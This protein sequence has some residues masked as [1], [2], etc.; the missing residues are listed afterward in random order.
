MKKYLLILIFYTSI[1][2][3]L[4][5]STIL[6]PNGMVIPSMTQANRPASPTTGQLIYQTDGTT[7][8]YIWNG[9][10]WMTVSGSGGGSGTVTNVSANAPISVTNS[11]TTPSLSISQA[12]AT[13]NGF[14]SSSD[15]TTFNNKQN[16][17]PKAD[18]F[19]NGYL[20]G[21]DWY[22]FNTKFSLP[23]FTAG[24]VFFSKNSA[25]GES[26]DHFFFNDTEKRLELKGLN[27]GTP[28][29]GTANWISGVFGG[30][31]GNKVVMGVNTGEATIGGHNYNFT[32]WTPLIINP[33]GA[34]KI[35]SLI[36]TG[37]RMVVAEADGTLSSQSMVAREVLPPL[38]NFDSVGNSYTKIIKATNST[39]GYLSS[40]D[41]SIF[42]N[43]QNALSNANTS[44]SGILTNA[45]WNIFYGKFT[46]P[47]LTSGSLLFSNGSSITENNSNLFWNNSSNRLGIKSLY[48]SSSLTVNSADNQWFAA[49]F[50]GTGTGRVVLGNIQN[51]ATIGALSNDFGS[52][53][54]LAIN[55][56]GGN[57]VIGNHTPTEKLQVI[58]NGTFSN[59]LAVGSNVF[60][61]PST[62][63]EINST[64]GTLLLPRLISSTISGIASPLNGMMA[65]NSEKHEIAFY[66]NNLWTDLLFNDQRL[67]ASTNITQTFSYTGGTQTWTVPTGVTFVE[68]TANGASGGASLDNIG[69]WQVFVKAGGLGGRVT[70]TLA[71]TP[72]QVLN[73]VVGGSGG[74]PVGGF[75]GGGGG[76][77]NQENF[78]AGGGGGATDIRIGGAGLADRVLVAGGGGGGAFC[79]T[80]TNMG[81]VGGGLTAAG[82]VYVGQ[83]GQSTGGSGASLGLGTACGN[84]HSNVNTFYS[85]GGGGGYYGGGA[86]CIP[87]YGEGGGGGSSYTDAGLATNVV[88]TAGVNSGNG[89]LTITYVS[90]LRQNPYLDGTNFS[91]IPASSIVGGNLTQQGNTFN[92]INQLVKTDGIGKLPTIDGSNLTNISV[93]NI[94]SGT[95]PALNGSNLT[96]LNASNISSGTLGDLRLTANVTLQGNTFNG[97]NQLVK[98][99]SGGLLPALDGSNLS[100]L[101]ATNLSSGS[102]ADARL[103]SNVT[104]LG[105]TFNGNSQL[106]KNEANGKLPALDGSNLTN[107]TVANLASGTLPALN[108]SNLTNLN[109]TNFS[110][111]TVADARLTSNVT[112]LG[113]AFN[114][115]NQLVQLNGTGIFPTLNGSNLSNLNASN[116]SLG[117]LADARLTSNVTLLGNT[118]NGNSQLVQTTA[119]GLLPTIDGSNLTNLIINNLNGI[120]PITKGGT[121]TNTSFATGSIVFA[122]ASG[123]YSQNNA[124]L[125][126]NN[127][128]N[129]LGIGT[130]IPDANLHING[131][132]KIQNG[133]EGVN[134]ILKSDANGVATWANPSRTRSVFF[135]PNMINY[136]LSSETNGGV[137]ISL[138]T[139]STSKKPAVQFLDNNTGGINL[140]IPIPADWN[141]SSAFT[142]KLYS[143]H[144]ISTIGDFYFDYETSY[145]A[146]GGSIDA[147][148]AAGNLAVSV[149]TGDELIQKVSTLTLNPE[150]NT[151]MLQFKL[152]RKGT[153]ANDTASST[154]YLLGIKFEYMD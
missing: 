72:G 147:S 91:N 66:K 46:L 50:G 30:Q 8:L 152:I 60:Q 67:I 137:G 129:R 71:V 118:F 38:V 122:G 31:S 32:A 99:T 131:S 140:N 100:N 136:Q 10:A 139:N 116:I 7:G 75:N 111:G 97:T 78:L 107:I 112:L 104:L 11:S 88:H 138:I 106:I 134:K 109:A 102:V 65:Y 19:T 54:T 84:I 83:A 16:L 42:N 24:S 40:A 105:N 14:L 154:F 141:G 114:G 87:N 119:G 70:T 5:Q 33:G 28:N 17:L 39:N 9:I 89:S 98:T 142:V 127:T 121:G 151:T 117:T 1:S 115:N 133:S 56:D 85:G 81:F 35:G 124:Q 62:S 29:G 41:W 20:S 95:L 93:S 86:T 27:A 82:N 47:S 2:Q 80:S 23:T 6:L 101:N 123:N 79:T 144:S 55:P 108:G 148:G 15:W 43:K 120:V 57:V 48:P 44:T 51:K 21:S 25:I 153:H 18:A 92:G 4:G 12:N 61:S 126:F 59:R 36:G 3:L 110:T 146:D 94:A 103:T 73:I 113:N 52:W 76:A 135:D 125:F 53:T 132:L 34:T 64:T 145:V 74:S 130:N 26:N 128:N 96:D 58:G 68:I 45:D 149:I 37:T 90:S 143:T 69:S 77:F 63:F 49:D 13:T 150:V 22:T